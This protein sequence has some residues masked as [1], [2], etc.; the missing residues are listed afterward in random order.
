MKNHSDN[1]IRVGFLVNRFGQAGV[2]KFVLDLL[3]HLDHTRFQPYLFVVY[4]AKQDFIDLID[5]AVE[6]RYLN[7]QVGDNVRFHFTLAQALKRERIDVLHT[8]NWGTFAEGVL[9]KWL[10]RSIK[11]VYTQHGLEYYNIGQ[12]SPLKQR[13]RKLVYRTG[14]PRIDRVV[15]VSRI[16]ETF[17]REAM[18]ARDVQLIYNGIDLRHFA[19]Q[20][21]LRRA[22]IGVDDEDFVVM[23]VGRLVA[24]KNY[25][26]LMRA[27]KALHARVPRLRLVHIGTNA[28]E[29][30]EGEQ[31]FDYIRA[32]KLDEVVRLLGLR[33]DVHQILPLGDAFALTSL[34]EGLSLAI[35]EAQA[36]GLPA[37][38]TNVGGNHEIIEDGVNGFLVPSDDHAAVSAALE[39]LSR[40]PEC[41]REMAANALRLVQEKFDIRQMISSYQQAYLAITNGRS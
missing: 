7:R 31:V 18:G 14:L 5:P 40:E 27:I 20:T 13:L 3:N 36:A 30:Q 10:C 39:T 35:L 2:E 21:P 41:R 33:N 38:V 26:C 8:N 28:R 4:Y 15:S 25:M 37:V 22:D 9:A 23:S 6:V 11:V 1:R 12:A 29:V 34:S 32:E 19:P 24:V 16:G 17:L